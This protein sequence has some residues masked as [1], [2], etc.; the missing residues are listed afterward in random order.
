VVVG[1]GT[2]GSTDGKPDV[3]LQNTSTRAFT[4]WHMNDNVVGTKTNVAQVP[5]A[6]WKV[7]G[8]GDFNSDHKSDIVFQNLSTSQLL[9]WY[10]NGTVYSTNAVCTPPAG[11]MNFSAVV[12]LSGKGYPDIVYQHTGGTAPGVLHM[13]ANFKITSQS[14]LPAPAADQNVAGPK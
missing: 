10:M 5:T 12:N 6:G 13:G 3:L 1:V 2:F 4:V 9:V 8:V 14:T 11:V 7:I